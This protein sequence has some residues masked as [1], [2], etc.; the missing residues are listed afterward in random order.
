MRLLRT[1]CV[2]LVFLNSSFPAKAQGLGDA[3]ERFAGT[4]VAIDDR[5]RARVCA[6]PG[7][8]SLGW[9]DAGGSAVEA[10]CA[11]TGERLVL[12]L[13]AQTVGQ[14]RVR[15]GESVQAE[16]QGQGFRLSVGAVTESA[17]R[18][19]RVILRNSRTG[20]RF[21]ARMDP[22]GRM[23]VSTEQDSR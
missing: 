17:G 21:A 15:R 18:D 10:R 23:I 11:A 4:A 3:A 8:F 13:S 16:A 19:G 6:T 7:G 20:Q 9:A 1:A 5:L 14:A 22:V 2:V 12:P